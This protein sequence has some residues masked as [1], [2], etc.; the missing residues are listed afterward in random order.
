MAACCH[1]FQPDDPRFA[2]LDAFIAEA[3]T[4]PGSLIAVLHRAQELFGFLPREVQARIAAGLGIAPSQVYGVVTFY[5]LFST[6]PVGRYPISVCMGTACYVKGADRVLKEIQSELQ[7]QPGQVT[8]DGLFSLEV[9]RCIGACSLA[10]A[11]T[12]DGEV[13]GGLN[14]AGVR[15]LLADFRQRAGLAAT[16]DQVA[17]AVARSEVS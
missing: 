5:N 13:Y 11:I 8:P 10:P 17:P 15:K 16:P 1:G 12:V 7:I 4:V 3:R 9:C 6:E 14:E 2:E